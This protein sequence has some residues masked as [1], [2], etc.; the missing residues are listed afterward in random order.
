MKIIKLKQNSPEWLNW[1]AD[2]IGASDIGIILGYNPYKTP[3]RL[4]N[5]KCGYV[6]DEF[7]N[8]ATQYG[9]E[10]EPLALAW[11]E[12]HF[13]R[14]FESICAEHSDYP[15]MRA[16]FDALNL[17]EN[18]VVEI[19]SPYNEGSLEEMKRG[20]IPKTYLAQLQWQMMIADSGIGYLAVWDGKECFLK[21]YEVD[22]ELQDKMK[23]AAIIF[24][25][26]LQRGKPPEATLK[27]YPKIEISNEDAFEKL[28]KYERA[29]KL[30]R[31]QDQILKELKPWIESMAN[32]QNCIL[33]NL[34]VTTSDG[35]ILYDYK[36]MREAGIDLDLYQKRS[37]SYSKISLLKTST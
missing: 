26:N 17:K 3:L 36:A 21:I 8:K 31:E 15:F 37:K 22:E 25:D 29:L 13:G 20:K 27:D 5:E 1:R 2:G 6:S 16:S 30:K 23:E 7:S 32:G 33:G 34:K 14:D 28:A 4:Y 24:W 35:N 10:Q 11:L 18:I 19:K 12:D 9:K